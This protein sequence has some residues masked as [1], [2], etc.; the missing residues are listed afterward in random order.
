[1]T[2]SDRSKLWRERHDAKTW[3]FTAIK[4]IRDYLD[5]IWEKS[6]LTK[7]DATIEA[8]KLL[9]EKQKNENKNDQT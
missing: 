2:D 6:K 9:E 7:Q 1:M 3:G 8:F 4:S 5:L